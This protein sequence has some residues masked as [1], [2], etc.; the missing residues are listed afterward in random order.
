MYLQAPKK[1][2]T[3]GTISLVSA[4]VTCLAAS[5]QQDRLNRVR[6]NFRDALAVIQLTLRSQAA[7]IICVLLSIAATCLSC[8]AV[9]HAI[10]VCSSC[11]TLIARLLPPA[12]PPLS[13]S[14]TRALCLAVYALPSWG[15][16]CR[17]TAAGTCAC[18]SFTP[19]ANYQTRLAHPLFTPLLPE[20][21][22]GRFALPAKFSDAARAD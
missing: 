8:A 4:A 2:T 9:P 11:G 1:S 6:F 21:R 5:A 18:A 10:A 19:P 7:L 13:Q 22:C 14:L 16:D 3:S 15:S 20:T 17:G 12:Q